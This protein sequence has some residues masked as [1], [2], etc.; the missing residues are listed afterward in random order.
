[1]E[2]PASI[3]VPRDSGGILAYNIQVIKCENTF[4]VLNVFVSMDAYS[5]DQIKGV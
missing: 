4:Q 2:E 1:M 3:P 5:H